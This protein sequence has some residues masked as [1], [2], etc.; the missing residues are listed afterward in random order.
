MSQTLERITDNE[1][2]KQTN[3]KLEQEDTVIK[4]S[5]KL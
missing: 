5:K 4:G 2:F 1:G 3:S